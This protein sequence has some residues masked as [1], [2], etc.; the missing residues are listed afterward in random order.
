[1][2]GEAHGLVALDRAGAQ[3][4]Q[5][6]RLAAVRDERGE[7]FDLEAQGATPAMLRQHLRLRALIVVVLGLVFGAATGAVLSALVVS[8]V[9]VTANATEAQPPLVLSVDWRLVGIGVALYALAAALLVGLAT[10]RAFH[11]RSAGRFA[12]VGW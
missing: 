1:M 5:T 6:R 10:W 8:L 4:A 12:E 3:P 2:R 7:L 11:A 9:K